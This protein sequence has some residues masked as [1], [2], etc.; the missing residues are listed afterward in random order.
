MKKVVLITGSSKGIGAEIATAFAKEN[1]KVVL[2][3]LSSVNEMNLLKDKL[4]KYNKDI[5]AIQCDITKYDQVE[6]MYTKI[7]NTFGSVDIL[8]NN[9]G[10]SY[11]G[12]F[13]SMKPYQ[14][15][16]VIS[17]NLVSTINC[18]NICIPNMVNK[19][20]GVIINISSVF[21][22]GA[23][24][25]V[26]YSCTKGA[27]NSFT[28]ALSKELGLSGIRV[29]AI[30]PGIIETT[31]NAHLNEEEKE[32]IKENI[33]LNKIGTP[34]DVANLSLFLAKEESSYITGQ[35]INVDGGWL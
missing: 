12:L 21:A 6:K 27:I 24:C 10:I 26:V 34:K 11:T 4:L 22:D 20:S 25:E 14:W 18:S 15:E 35:I 16:K 7:K 13:Q 1:Y 30:S 19:K 29:N 28:K 23:S 3:C 33:S 5:L 31:M 2:N 32:E 17:T 9:A 8:I